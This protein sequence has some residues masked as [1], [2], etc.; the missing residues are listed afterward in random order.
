MERK[1]YLC[2]SLTEDEIKYVRGI[3]WKSA[4]K[5]RRDDYKRNYIEGISIDDENINE[6]ILMVEDRFD[7]Y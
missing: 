1:K 4:R 5:C 6:K 3:I 7:S 2:E